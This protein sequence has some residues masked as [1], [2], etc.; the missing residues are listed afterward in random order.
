MVEIV[1]FSARPKTYFAACIHRVVFTAYIYLQ[2]KDVY[3]WT[4]CLMKQP[5]KEL[6]KP[7]QNTRI[8]LSI[9]YSIHNK[10]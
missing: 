9:V 3:L 4:L 10:T 2:I 8:I 5:A 1:E 6:I 7:Q